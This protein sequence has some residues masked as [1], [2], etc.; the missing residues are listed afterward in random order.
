MSTAPDNLYTQGNTALLQLPQTALFCSRDYPPGIEQ[1]TFMWAMEQRYRSNCVLSGFHSRLEQTVFRYLLRGPQQPIVYALG[2][3]IQPNLRLE[4]GPEI[5]AGRLLFVSS[6][7]PE[8]RSITQET[9]DSRNLLIVD[10]ASQFF[11]PYMAPGGNIEKLL[12]SPAAHSKPVY[13]LDLPENQALLA[14]GALPFRPGGVFGR[15]TSR[16]T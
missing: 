12:A 5:L 16:P 10:M 11:V 13:T 15:H 1:L 7:A 4:Y 2:R 3:G 8:V 9:A 14:A 6:F